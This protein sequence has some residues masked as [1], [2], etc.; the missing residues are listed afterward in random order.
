MYSIVNLQ[1][2]LFF[3]E[4]EETKMYCRKKDEDPE[5]EMIEINGD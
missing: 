2:A 1:V 5:V 3:K 4:T